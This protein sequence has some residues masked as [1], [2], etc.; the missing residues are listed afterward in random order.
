[1]V[2]VEVPDDDAGEESVLGADQVRLSRPG[3]ALPVNDLSALEA[4]DETMPARRDIVGTVA[5]GLRRGRRCRLILGAPD[6]TPSQTAQAAYL[7][8]GAEAAQMAGA[9]SASRRHAPAAL[10]ARLRTTLQARAGGEPVYHRMGLET[11]ST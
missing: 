1:M 9:A 10:F 3:P 6:R 2:A 5:S 8:N 11:A 7:G 4:V